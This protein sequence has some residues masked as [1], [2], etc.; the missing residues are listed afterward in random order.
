MMKTAIIYGPRDIR[1]EE[2][3]K[4]DIGP[5]D[6]LVQVKASGICGSDVH[7][8]LGTAYGR[9][10]WDYP[11]NSGHEY[12]GDVVEVGHQVK[13]F[14]EGDKV[15]LGVSWTSG[16]LGAFSDFVHIPDADTSLCRV[17]QEITYTNG[18]LLETFLVAF[19]GY[20]RPQPSLDDRI[21]ILG[22]GTIGLCVLLLCKARGIQEITV[23]EPSARR[24]TLAE[25]IGARTVNPAEENLEEF[26]MST[27]HGKGTNVTFEC[28]G[29]EETL[30]QSFALTRR[31]GKISL[32]GHY[33]TTPRFN[34]EDVIVKSLSVFGPEYGHAF[35]D[36]A[37]QLL[38]DEQVDLTQLVSHR[39]PIE[40]AEEAFETASDVNRSVKAL[41]SAGVTD[42]VPVPALSK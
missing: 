3:A 4:P 5:D 2:V 6:V 18:V 37:L 26:V 25:Q 13:R 41:F 36:E 20:H 15:T 11:M 23:S 24:R 32:I 16:H 34:I 28:A 30:N 31:E 19:N 35:F 40:K 27:T 17:P 29:E 1:V 42:Q 21:L 22:A 7:R 39:Y 12:C 9:A 10:Y 38:L 8:Y 33:K 14:G